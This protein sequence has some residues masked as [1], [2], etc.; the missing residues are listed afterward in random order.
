MLL[1]MLLTL[2]SGHTQHLASPHVRL[3]CQK[4][5]TYRTGKVHCHN[6]LRHNQPPS[7]TS[8]KDYANIYKPLSNPKNP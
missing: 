8:Y 3:L 2:R 4:L 5:L 6:L 1:L 7:F